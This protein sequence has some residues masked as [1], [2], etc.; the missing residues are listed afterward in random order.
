MSEEKNLSEEQIALTKKVQ[1]FKAFLLENAENYIQ[2]FFNVKTGR[3]KNFNGKKL[4]DLEKFLWHSIDFNRKVKYCF[5]SGNIGSCIYYSM[6]LEN[7][8]EEKFS[9]TAGEMNQAKIRLG[10]DTYSETLLKIAVSRK[11][12]KV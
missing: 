10:L 9:F 4:N 7:F 11:I 1:E 12:L 6:H 2:K 8:L 3:M 5:G